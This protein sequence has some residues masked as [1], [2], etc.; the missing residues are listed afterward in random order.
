M[1]NDPEDKFNYV[2]KIYLADSKGR[3][4]KEIKRKN[5]GK[6][7]FELLNIDKYLLGDNSFDDPW[8]QAL[9]MKN[10]NR[11]KDVLIQ[12]YLNYPSGEWKVNST[13]AKILDKT[14]F[15]LKSNPA[16][17]VEIGSH[18]DS[19]GSDLFNLQLSEKRAKAVLNYLISNH[20]ERKRLLAKGYGETKLLNKCK[21]D[22]ECED[23]EHTINRRTE[24][25][26]YLKK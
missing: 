1:L 2:Q 7:Q 12:E 17:D 14:I 26:L 8:L 21:N 20:I 4:Y 24:F 13:I 6:F 16:Y 23:S 10:K 25:R 15:V 22:V 11:T 18:S 9:N 19:R 5:D 3:I